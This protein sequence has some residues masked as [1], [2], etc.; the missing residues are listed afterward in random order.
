[1]VERTEGRWCHGKLVI[2]ENKNSKN[3][4]KTGISSCRFFP[5]IGRESEKVQS[6]EYAGKRNRQELG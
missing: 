6:A 5:K 1:M 2:I 3:E 4:I